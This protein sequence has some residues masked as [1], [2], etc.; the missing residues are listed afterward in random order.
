M[1]TILLVHETRSSLQITVTGVDRVVSGVEFPIVGVLGVGV[2]RWGP[3]GFVQ[4]VAA[5]VLFPHSVHDEHHHQD[6]AE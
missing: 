4:G 2:G 5:F 3:L 1:H 6:G